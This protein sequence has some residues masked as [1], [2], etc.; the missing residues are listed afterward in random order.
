MV[1]LKIDPERPIVEIALDGRISKA[2][3]DD[4]SSRLE[5]EFQKHGKLRIVEVVHSFA[6]MDPAAYWDD[7]KFGFRHFRDFTRYA[8]VSDKK[9]AEVITALAA[10]IA[11]GEGRFF[12]LEKIDEARA[13]VAEGLPPAR[14]AGAN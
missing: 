5:A 14:P 1:E 8:V 7:I 11:P 12:P 10:P 6:G 4:I 3:F 13:W 9:W 2:E